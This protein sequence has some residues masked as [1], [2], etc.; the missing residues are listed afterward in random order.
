MSHTCFLHLMHKVWLSYVMDGIR[1]V[2][3]VHFRNLLFAGAA[4]F[5]DGGSGVES[6]LRIIKALCINQDIKLVQNV[7]TTLKSNWVKGK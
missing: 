4:I 2:Q 3:I 6:I 7:C 1:D 5:G